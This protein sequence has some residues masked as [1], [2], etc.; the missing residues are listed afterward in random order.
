MF[1]KCRVIWRQKKYGTT[2]IAIKPKV[3]AVTISE[4]AGTAGMN[5]KFGDFR[6]AENIYISCS[7][8]DRRYPGK[9]S[10]F[11]KDRICRF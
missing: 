4:K 2:S 6:S 3:S 1:M 11:N 7:D 8:I 9:N 5:M 10:N